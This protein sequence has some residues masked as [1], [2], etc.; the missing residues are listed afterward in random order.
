M[1]TETERLVYSLEFAQKVATFVEADMQP[2]NLNSLLLIPGE[3]DIITEQED[4]GIG[5]EPWVILP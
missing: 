1:S 5:G 2:E 3:R 4:H